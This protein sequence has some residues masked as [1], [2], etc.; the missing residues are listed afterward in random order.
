MFYFVEKHH[1]NYLPA[2]VPD[3]RDYVGADVSD[4]FYH[5]LWGWY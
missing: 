3:T 4:C 2:F 5:A 1:A